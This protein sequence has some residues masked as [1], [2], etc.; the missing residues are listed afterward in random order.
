METFNSDSNKPTFHSYLHKT[1][2]INPEFMWLRFLMPFSRGSGKHPR[3]STKSWLWF[4]Q[5][6]VLCDKT[7]ILVSQSWLYIHFGLS[8]FCSMRCPVHCW[9]SN[10]VPSLYSLK[11]SSTFSVMKI[12]NVLKTLADVPWGAESPYF[13]FFL[14]SCVFWLYF[15]FLFLLKYSWFTMFLLFLLY[16]KVTQSHTV[17]CAIQ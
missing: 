17:P 16:S 12:Q 8:N 11:D 15:F 14:I 9:M 4:I 10:S 5:L 7:P 6:C 13:F 2:A 1:L 3:L